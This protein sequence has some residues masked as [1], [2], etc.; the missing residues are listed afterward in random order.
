MEIQGNTMN[1]VECSLALRDRF[2]QNELLLSVS[3]LVHWILPVT[4]DCP[5]VRHHFLVY[6]LTFL[7][8]PMTPRFF[9]DEF[10]LL[11]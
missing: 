3:T 1:L 5:W 8:V 6:C 2:R 10:G 4:Q 11:P 7:G 9:Y